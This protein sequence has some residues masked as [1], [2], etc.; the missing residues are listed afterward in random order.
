M[1]AK[2]K[3]IE[4]A[5][6]ERVQILLPW[7]IKKTLKREEEE[8]VREHVEH[9]RQCSEEAKL[10]QSLSSALASPEEIQE[11]NIHRAY[12]NI[13]RKLDLMQ[14]KPKLSTWFQNL[15]SPAGWMP[16]AA[17]QFMVIIGLVVTLAT[18]HVSAPS[19]HALGSRSSEAANVV[20]VFHSNTTVADMQRVLR[21]SGAVIVGGPTIT[22]A[23]MLSIS[24]TDLIAAIA[25]L[26]SEPEIALVESLAAKDTEK[27]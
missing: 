3:K 26:R 13:S 11:P 24:N 23:Y 16:V 19:Y 4:A 12:S 9:C 21:A 2:H 10:A 14:N 25:R 8:I 15:F 20:V 6:C 27:R 1:N 18:E 17:V 7:F 22:D 5:Q